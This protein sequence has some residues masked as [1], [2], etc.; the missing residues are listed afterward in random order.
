MLRLTWAAVIVSVLSALVFGGQLYEM[1]TGGTATDN[2]V[3]YAGVQANASSDQA[4]AAQ[5]F[6]DTAEDINGRMSDAVEQLAAAAKNAKAGIGATQRAMR[7]DQRAWVVWKA[8]DGAPVLDKP[9]KIDTYFTNTGRTPAKNVKVFCRVQPAIDEA[10]VDFGAAVFEKRA[11]IIAPND[12]NS[13]C[14]LNPLTI[15]KVTQDVLDTFSTKSKIEFNYGLITYDDI[16]GQKHWLSFCRSMD[17]DGRAW[18]ACA[19]HNDT[20]DGDPPKEKQRKAN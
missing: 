4:D 1:I 10:E 18:N 11:T 17:P 9:W 15:P 3:K 20:G 12:A 5:Q 2:L 19:T 7:L 6:S 13:F 14:P 16:F 8:I